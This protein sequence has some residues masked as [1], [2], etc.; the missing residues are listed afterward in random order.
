M[1]TSITIRCSNCYEDD[2]KGTYYE[3]YLGSGMMCFCKEQLEKYYGI[4][5]KYDRNYRLLAAGDPPDEIYSKL[6]KPVENERINTEIY[7]NIKNGYEFTENMGQIPYYCETC[8]KLLSLFYF[9]MEK[10]GNIYTPK[11]DCYKCK[12]YFEPLEIIYEDEEDEE[13]DFDEDLSKTPSVN[14]GI[15]YKLIVKK[16]NSIQIISDKNEEKKLICRWCNCDIFIRDDEGD[17][18]WD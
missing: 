6:E 18:M 14:I 7:E 15:N 13:N 1:G 3:L 9:Q 2:R 5:R 8:N 10:N 17:I 4:N 12:N 11:Y 16:D